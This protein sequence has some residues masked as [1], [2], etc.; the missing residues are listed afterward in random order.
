MWQQPAYVV[1]TGFFE[2]STCYSEIVYSYGVV[3]IAGERLQ[4]LGFWLAPIA[5][6]QVDV[7][8][9]GRT[10]RNNGA[11]FFLSH[12]KSTNRKSRETQ[13]LKLFERV[14]SKRHANINEQHNKNIII[15]YQKNYSKNKLIWNTL[16]S[17]FFVLIRL[18][19]INYQIES[20]LW[21]SVCL[22]VVVCPTKEFFTHL[23][24]SPSLVKGYIF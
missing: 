20:M 4:N 10:F 18:S 6:E 23:E 24:T 21:S 9:S 13:D 16:S 7:F 8:L 14:L 11:R 5:F 3:I 1:P 17:W 15:V 22:F 12:S 2:Y 19:K